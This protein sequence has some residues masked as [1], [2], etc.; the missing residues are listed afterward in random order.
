MALVGPRPKALS[1][2]MKMVLGGAAGGLLV[3]LLWPIAP[4]TADE[5]AALAAE[6]VV[7]A[8]P[9]T[10]TPSSPVPLIST[11]IAR[12]VLGLLR[13][14]DLEKEGWRFWSQ[15]QPVVTTTGSPV[16]IAGATQG[17]A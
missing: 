15:V 4:L 13:Y 7:Y 14:A 12:Q 5:A 17:Q 1:P 3:W 9:G 10:P 8:A 6:G 11:S 2:G 16:V